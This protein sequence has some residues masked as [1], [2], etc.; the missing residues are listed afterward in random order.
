MFAG[1]TAPRL[2]ADAGNDGV[3]AATECGTSRPPS[4]DRT[5]SSD[6]DADTYYRPLARTWCSPLVVSHFATAPAS[7]SDAPNLAV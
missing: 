3:V 2:S 7:A 6:P 1:S 4:I 5:A